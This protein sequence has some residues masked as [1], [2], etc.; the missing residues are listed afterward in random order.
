M[1]LIHSFSTNAGPDTKVRPAAADP[2]SQLL[3]NRE[4]MKHIFTTLFLALNISLA[5]AQDPF[6]Y[7]LLR[8]APFK[9]SAFRK[10]SE[11]EYRDYAAMVLQLSRQDQPA[12]SP[13]TPGSPQQT[14]QQRFQDLW[15]SDSISRST[16]S[17]APR[18]VAS[19]ISRSSSRP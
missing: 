11:A 5:A 18:S 14:P 2:F 3:Q 6:G 4:F 12:R 17:S 9:L 10:P 19:A 8:H 1:C 7:E 13:G 16:S 15:L